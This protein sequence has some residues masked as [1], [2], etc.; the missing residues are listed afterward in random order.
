MRK[1]NVFVILLTLTVISI[2]AAS[3]E[4]KWFSLNAG[5]EKAKAEKKPMIV[6]FYFGKGCPRCEALQ[7]GVYDN[8]TIAKKIMDDFIPIRVDL[9]KPLTDEEKKLGNKYD[10]KNDCLLLFLDDKA[11]IIKDPSGKS[12]CFVSSVDAEWFVKYL[13][14]IKANQSK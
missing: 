8:P 11:N 1:V 4:I 14:M 5:M 2:A 10:Y 6:D 12:L 3:D 7:K 9:T 13:D